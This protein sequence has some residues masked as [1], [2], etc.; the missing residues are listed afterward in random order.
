MSNI[1]KSLSFIETLQ[2]YGIDEEKRTIF[3]SGD[4]DSPQIEQLVTNLYLLNSKDAF[5]ETH[6][7]PIKIILNSGGGYDHLMLNAYD[8]ITYSEAPVYT[9]VAGMACSAA[10]LLLVCGD[11][12]F[13]TENS[14]S[15]FHKGRVS[16]EGDEDE[17]NASAEINR[18]ISDRY[19]KLLGR[20][21]TKSAQWWFDRSKQEGQLWLAPK[22]MLEYGVI[23]GILP[24]PRR[25]LES[26]PARKIKLSRTMEELDE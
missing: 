14:W 11:K 17:I 1:I 21:T 9:I 12:R 2:E 26:L 25:D 22:Q 24:R 18:K 10:T 16:L 19:W 13:C 8:A 23:D 20:H 4:I 3:F 6:Q 5:P 15:M 7:N